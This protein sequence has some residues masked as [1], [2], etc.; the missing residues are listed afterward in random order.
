MFWFK[1]RSIFYGNLTQF[2]LKRILVMETKDCF[3][4][5]T[6]GKGTS[7]NQTFSA[8]IIIYNTDNKTFGELNWKQH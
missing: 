6:N 5:K 8:F 4:K 3:P 2:S 1:N 7:Q